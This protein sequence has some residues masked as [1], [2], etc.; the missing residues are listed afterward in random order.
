MIQDLIERRF[1]VS[2]HPHYLATLLHN[3]GFSYQKARVVSDH[4]K[5]AKRL[6]WRRTTWPAM[7]RHAKQRKALRLFG[8]EARFAQ[9]GSLSSTWAP[10]GAQ[11]EVPTSG[12]RNGY[13]VFGLI[14]YC[15]GRL[16][17]K[18]QEG[19]FHSES[20][21]AFLLDGLAQTRR[22]VVVIHDG[23]R[24]RFSQNN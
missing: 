19:R 9:W 17:S 15:S 5:E 22:H 10:T 6:E 7:L 1:G 3:L 23:V 14:D 18:A 2:Y 16:F 12:K 21:A 24:Y 20:S 13:K 8:A 11:P 4:L